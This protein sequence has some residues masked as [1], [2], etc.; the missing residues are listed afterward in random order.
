MTHVR[1]VRVASG[2]GRPEAGAEGASV[3]HEEVPMA[4]GY[5]N[6][7]LSAPLA[8]GTLGRS[9]GTHGAESR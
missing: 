9:P 5:R 1:A 3:P 7:D 6:D 2:A 8:G 4:I